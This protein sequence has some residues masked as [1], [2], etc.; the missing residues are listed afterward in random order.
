[1]VPPPNEQCGSPS[2]APW[3]KQNK[4]NKFPIDETMPENEAKK[5]LKANTDEDQLTERYEAESNSWIKAYK[6]WLFE[7]IDCR[8]ILSQFACDLSNVP[9]SRSL[10]EIIS[11]V[12]AKEKT[13]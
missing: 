12:V 7:M 11:G 13:S 4:P 8:I 3:R 6:S 5:R 2:T 10:N 9:S 1:M